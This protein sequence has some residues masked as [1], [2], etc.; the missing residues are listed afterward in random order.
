[1]DP[2]RVSYEKVLRRVSRISGLV[3]SVHALPIPESRDVF[4]VYA[5]RH[6]ILARPDTLN[7]VFL[8]LT[9][10]SSAIGRTAWEARA[11][12]LCEAMERWSCVYQG[13]EPLIFGSY[14]R[15]APAAV[16]PNTTLQFSDAQYAQRV[17]RN[18][19]CSNA[20]EFIPEPLPP[21]LEASWC[22]VWS[23]T[24]NTWRYA[25]ASSCYFG[26]RDE[27]GVFAAADSRGVAAGPSLEFCVWN[28]LLELIQTDAAALWHANFLPAPLVDVGSFQ[29]DYFDDIIAVHDRL[30]RD[31]WVLD[32]TADLPGVP[33]FAAVS[34]DRRTG[35]VVK[36]F[37]AHPQARRSLLRALME[38]SQMLANVCREGEKA[39]AAHETEPSPPSASGHLPAQTH[40]VP[41]TRLHVRTRDDY[42]ARPGPSTLQDLIG[43]LADRN[44]EVLMQD[45]SRPEVGLRVVRVLAP[46]LRSWFGRFAPGRLYTV[47]VVM[48]ARE[49]ERP[50]TQM[51]TVPIEDCTTVLRGP[52]IES[53]LQK[54]ID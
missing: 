11:L 7:A 45:V 43:M 51:N 47:P 10:Q 2:L 1:M 46:G 23:L 13:F 17:E 31:L 14:E 8:N 32:V 30:G 50:E 52:E 40:L 16:R 22:P 49:R 44:I 5:A 34:R 9:T 20:A 36:G 12:A 26:L 28:G 53:F 4:H 37:G 25:L 38:C 42:T 3:R 15:L 33:V 19:R 41:S 48:G 29:A 6:P 35:N 54:N 24:H 21:D 18:R 39:P 27:G